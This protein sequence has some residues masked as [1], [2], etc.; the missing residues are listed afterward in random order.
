MS[1]FPNFA[2]PPLDQ[3]IKQ[4]LLKMM[5]GGAFK[6]TGKLPPEEV[7]A[8]ELGVSRTAIRDAL[9]ALEAEG[10]IN[11]RRGIG[12]VIN[13]P[14]LEV[15]GRL[16]LEMEFLDTVAEAGYKPAVAFARPFVTEASPVA[17]KR[18]QVKPG[19]KIYRVERLI[20]ADTTPVIFCRDY[21][22]YD[23]IQDFSFRDEELQE[24]VFNFLKRYCH[25]EV[26]TDLTEVIPMQ[27]DAQ[28]ASLLG[29]KPGEPLLHLDE[30]GY[31]LEQIPIL[32]SQEYYR[33]G[34]LRFTLLRRKI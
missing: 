19:T 28:V 9:A 11:R 1:V 32:W 18:L 4:A 2:A 20:M 26:V 21:F 27:A 25:Q 22:A 8:R 14:V 16:D 31:N 3:Q 13:Q 15:T 24:P 34:V 7:L 23:L 6:D 5:R 29:I 33:L 30:V 10:F 17:A 12:T